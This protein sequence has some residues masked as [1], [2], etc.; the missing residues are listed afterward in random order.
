MDIGHKIY[1]IRKTNNLTQEEFAALF[2]VSRQT[3]SNWENNRTYPDMD[4]LKMM[5][6]K[7]DISFDTLLKEDAELI[8]KIDNT[9]KKVK[10]MTWI[11]AVVVLLIIVLFVWKAMPGIVSKC[12]YNPGEI[13]ASETSGDD[14]YSIEASQMATDISVYSEL[15]VPCRKYD[16]VES[17]PLGYGRYNIVIRQ[18]VHPTNT[19]AKTIA[20]QIT[21]NNLVLYN[22]DALQRP[23]GNAFEWTV[24]TRDAGKTLEENLTDKN[25]SMAM[26][27]DKDE[28]A[29][30]LKELNKNQTYI[31]YVS[32]DEVMDYEDVSGLLAPYD[33]MMT[34]TGIVTS[35]EPHHDIIGM[36][37][38]F[39][40][41]V[42]PF[43][44]V[45]YPYLLG[46]EGIET[47]EYD[48]SSDS[49][50]EERFAKEHFISMLKYISEQKI[51]LEMLEPEK[52]A[53]GIAEESYFTDKI[54]YI[55]ENGLKVYGV[56]VAADRETLL[57]LNADE[58]VYSIATEIY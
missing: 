5:S 29:V 22:P 50:E 4:T 49:I 53:D 55:E 46:T 25:P 10:K 21:R 52:Y 56:A 54:R 36:Y 14:G 15:F 23:V 3:V 17:E 40:G 33:V 24:N 35:K 39:S 7:F 37:N 20:G 43:D 51:F 18:S 16:F 27:G 42:L 45:K 28:A 19:G 2:H 48:G 41:A 47:G 1:R 30:N 31:G 13:I 57:E 58:N 6:D 9:K 38:S 32:F 12:Y 34:W 44:S 8:R 26:S 11:I